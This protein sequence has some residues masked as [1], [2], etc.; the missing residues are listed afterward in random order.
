[1]LKAQTPYMLRNDGQVFECKPVHPYIIYSI[2]DD[3][4]VNLYDLIVTNNW[5]LDWYYI[6]TN[7][8]WVKEKI[9][10]C[11]QYL[12]DAF[13]NDCEVDLFYNFGICKED[14]NQYIAK[15]SIEPKKLSH[16]I[17]QNYI[18]TCEALFND[19]N[20][21]CNQEFLRFRTS[22]MFYGGSGNGIYFR[23]SSVGFNWFNY[24]WEIVYNNRNWISDI[25]IVADTQAGKKEPHLYY[26]LNGPVNRMSADKF[27]QLKGNPIVEQVSQDLNYLILNNKG[28]LNEV[29]GDCGPFHNHRKFLLYR[30][31]YLDN[32]F[33]LDK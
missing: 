32:W 5:I 14:L 27:I 29:F 20:D 31:T 21:K 7:Q 25:T 2:E 19:L 30:K 3:F 13:N 22:G 11:I 6:H 24:I 15:Y 26:N 33:T 28:S 18:K 8:I 12:A 23:V 9:L 16:P 17:D 1:M 10:E 4:R